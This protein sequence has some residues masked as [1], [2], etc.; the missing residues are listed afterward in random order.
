MGDSD[1]ALS[2]SP[3]AKISANGRVPC[4]APRARLRSSCRCA[5]SVACGAL[6]VAPW[7]GLERRRSLIEGLRDP[8]PMSL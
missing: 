2:A 4:S 1:S 6:E 8:R 5:S 7:C 3:F